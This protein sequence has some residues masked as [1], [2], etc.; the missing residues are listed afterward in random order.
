MHILVECGHSLSSAGLP[1]IAFHFSVAGLEIL[2]LLSPAAAQRSAYAQAIHGGAGQAGARAPLRRIVGETGLALDPTDGGRMSEVE[3][4]SA[5]SA[6]GVVVVSVDADNAAAVDAAAVASF[7][8][9]CCLK[10]VGC[11]SGC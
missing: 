7:V 6:P 3:L 8:Y 10:R 11:A 4:V 5:A 2:V 9:V 1:P